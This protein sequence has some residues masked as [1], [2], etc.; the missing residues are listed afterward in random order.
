MGMYDGADVHLPAVLVAGN[1][2]RIK[3][4]VGTWEQLLKYSNRWQDVELVG[5]L[6]VLCKIYHPEAAVAYM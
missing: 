2:H 4:E 1:F 3:W 6:D 5:N